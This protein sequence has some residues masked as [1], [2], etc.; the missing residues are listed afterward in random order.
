MPYKLFFVL[1]L[2]AP[3]LW[4]KTD[5]YQLLK[6]KPIQPLESYNAFLETNTTDANTQFNKELYDYWMRTL[7]KRQFHL[8]NPDLDKDYVVEDINVNDSMSA[9][10]RALTED[11][12]YM[13]VLMLSAVGG[14]VLMPASFTNWEEDAL[15]GSSLTDGW[16]D[17]VTTKPVWDEDDLGT[18]YLGHPMSGAIYYAM[19]RNDGLNIFESALYTT[20]MSTFLWEYGYESFAEIPSIQDLV[21]TPLFGAI[22]GE[23]MHV[24][25]LKLDENKG[26]IWGSKG[27]GSVSYYF[28]DPMGNMA[29][30]MSEFFDVSV[31]M[32]FAS[33]QRYQDTSQFRYSNEQ[34]YPE[35]FEDRD[36]G[37]M[38]TFY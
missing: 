7:L 22:L 1:L 25:E 23:G 35:R 20:V 32:E 30:G 2:T 28:L 13:Q 26:V 33:F 8:F 14:L 9:E 17:N 37:F 24:L 12:I 34:A 38:L 21:V 15:Q 19:A 6:S 10:A 5:I 31:T 4:A 16:V 3:Q 18:N 36:Y 27:L 29:T 11:T